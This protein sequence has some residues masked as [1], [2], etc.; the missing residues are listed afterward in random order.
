MTSKFDPD[1]L[2]LQLLWPAG[3]TDTNGN[4]AVVMPIRIQLRAVGTSAW[5]N[6]PELMFH[7]SLSVRF[8]KKIVLSW[9]APPTPIGDQPYNN[10][11]WHSFHN[12]P[13]QA[14]VPV[15]VGAW[16]AQASF[17][18][19]VAKNAT[20]RVKRSQDGF[21]LYL[22]PAVFPRGKRWNISMI[23]GAISRPGSWAASGLV[24]NPA[25]YTPGP[26][27]MFHWIGGGPVFYTINVTSL[28]AASIVESCVVMRFASV[29]NKKPIPKP[30][31][32]SIEVRGRN[33]NVTQL[34]CE[35]AALIKIWN[36]VAFDGASTSE[37][38]A[39]HFFHALAGNQTSDRVPETYCNLPEISAWHADNIVN[40]RKVSA[41][42]D[43]R[44]WRESLNAIAGAGLAKLKEG[45]LWGVARQR[46]THLL[47]VPARQVF[48]HLNIFNLNWNKSFAPVPD[49]AR[50]S[51]R[52]RALN[53]D[54][55]ERL[56]LRPGISAAEVNRIVNLDAVAIVDATQVEEFFTLYLAAAQHRDVI[57]SFETWFEGLACEEGDIIQLN[58]LCL[59][60]RHASG[61]IV[62]VERNGS[63]EVVSVVLDSAIDPND[64]QGLET[65]LDLA[66][67]EDMA[68]QGV[69][70]GA[71][72]ATGP[73]PVNQPL[74]ALSST[75]KRIVFE[76]PFLNDD[77]KP[78]NMVMLGPRQMEMSRF[79]V[80]Q[81]EPADDFK[82]TLTMVPEAPEMWGP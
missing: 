6:L 41:V 56:V 68:A 63:D 9:D 20:A 26:Y 23:R 54:Q 81:V 7:S 19:G 82:F 25:T 30:G 43:G 2:W 48:S 3:M 57:F 15:G 58:H 28:Y 75:S 72:I 13:A 17:N 10:G 53:F 67:L 51:F 21:T 37:N 27:S 79:E 39:D 1:E 32:A 4:V 12:V 69:E 8:S 22:D 42:F 78:Q 44:E 16:V 49:A 31:N 59:S 45:R 74:V 5:I 64:E 66:T 18:G 60:E 36:G 14:A 62:E 73:G 77:V 29:W 47:G 38:P 52:N 34:A 24:F 33:I 11:A 40:N 55:D 71:T 61:R 46:N 76:V 50:V 35:G 65:V 80:T 70:L